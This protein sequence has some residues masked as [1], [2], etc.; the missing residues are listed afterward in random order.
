MRFYG[1]CEASKPDNFG[2]KAGVVSMYSMYSV[3]FYTAQH[4]WDTK[5]SREKEDSYAP[6]PYTNQTNHDS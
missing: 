6:R 4:A 5:H 2:L 1:I 3:R